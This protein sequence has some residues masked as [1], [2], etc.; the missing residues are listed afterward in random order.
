MVVVG[1]ELREREVLQ[2]ALDLPDA[3]PVS[4]R[5]IDVERLPRDPLAPLLGVGA[6]GAHVVEPVAELDEDDADVL[7]HGHE[8]LADV[9]RLCLFAGVDVDLAE[10]GDPVDQL[11]HVGTELVAHLLASH[12]G[13]LDGVMEQG[14][15]QRVRV[16]AE[17]G[18]DAR[19]RHR[20][21]DVGL[22]A[23]PR[24]ALMGALRQRV[25]ANQHL[26]LLLTEVRGLGEEFVERHLPDGT[27]ELANSNSRNR[28]ARGCV[29]RRG[30]SGRRSRQAPADEARTLRRRCDRPGGCAP[31]PRAPPP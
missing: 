31:L 14:G 5:G 16:Q 26:A 13:V 23:E 18:E 24:L 19:H 9:L 12:V 28:L 4:Q 21:T 8:H 2:L 1:I 27:R 7:G 10:L 6:D 11:G 29:S 17:V 15:D 25:G 3:E 22:A 20:V 30:R